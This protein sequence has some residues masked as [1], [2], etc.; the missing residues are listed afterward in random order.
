MDETGTVSELTDAELVA[1]LPGIR[2]THDNKAHYK[3]I[4]QQRLLFYRCRDCGHWIYP[5]YPGCPACWSDDVV[6]EEVSGKGTVYL[7]CLFHQG[8]PIP[9]VDYS[10]PYPVAA[11]ELVEQEALRY[12]APL[13]GPGSTEAQLGAPVSLT[14][15]ERAGAPAFELAAR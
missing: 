6:V 10:T 11:I 12:V 9:G 1:R 15:I 2:L 5:R 13:V 4:L 14:W 7:Y 8:R 3:G